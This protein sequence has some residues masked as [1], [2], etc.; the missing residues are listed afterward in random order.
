MTVPTIP[1]PIFTFEKHV[2]EIDKT[3]D[4]KVDQEVFLDW[5]VDVDV[6]KNY[7]INVD[8]DLDL[9][10]NVAEL[11]WEVETPLFVTK[12]QTATVVEFGDSSVS[13]I[14]AQG[15]GFEY[16][17]QAAA[18]SDLT[19]FPVETFTEISFT[20]LID[21]NAGS[22]FVGTSIAAVDLIHF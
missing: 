18:T 10:G 15:A 22:N 19:H 1:F 17:G 3:L 16:A 11:E 20:A 12:F 2:I 21:E 5:D 8:V 9:K 7:D 14:L 4:I 13:Q 6:Y